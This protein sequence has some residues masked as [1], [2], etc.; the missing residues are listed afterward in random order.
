M[1]VRFASTLD[2]A[3]VLRQTDHGPV[4]GLTLFGA[5][6]AVEDG[7]QC[8]YAEAQEADSFLRAHFHEVDQFQL[9]LEGDGRIGSTPIEPILVQYADAYTPYGPIVGKTMGR[10]FLTLR[11]RPSVGPFYLPERRAER[12]R[13]DGR[14]VSGRHIPDAHGHD[15]RWRP[16]IGPEADGM[17][18]FAADLAPGDELAGIDDVDGD[19]QFYVVA[20]GTLHHEGREHPKLSTAFVAPDEA[21]PRFTAGTDGVTL[22]AVNFPVSAVASAA[23]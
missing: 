12:R 7:P 6:S 2:I 16:V 19:G 1:R 13:L 18:A 8:H 22:V 10:R 5:P 23:G 15:A 14:Q 21:R 3:P 4:R 9:F 17:A 20:R 11:V